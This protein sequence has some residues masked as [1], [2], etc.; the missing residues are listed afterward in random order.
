M[1]NSYGSYGIVYLIS[2]TVNN[3]PQHEVLWE[4]EQLNN[5]RLGVLSCT[6]LLISKR[7]RGLAR[8]LRKHQAAHGVMRHHSNHRGTPWD[9]SWDLGGSTGWSSGWWLM[10]NQ[11][12]EKY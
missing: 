1:F 6:N 4:Y 5:R 8:G 2:T 3:S 12:S 10:L 7:L 9:L 11:P